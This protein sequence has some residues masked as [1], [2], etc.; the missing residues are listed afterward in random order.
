MGNAVWTGVPLRDVLNAAGVKENAVYTGHYGMDPHLSGDPQKDPLS[1]G[2]PIWKA[3]D[4]HT[5]VAFEMN[6]QPIPALHGFPVRIVAPGWAGSTS[7]KWL[8]RIWV[9]DQVHDGAKMTGKSYRVP[10]YPVEPGPTCPMRI[11]SS[12][13]RC[14]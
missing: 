11:S 10:A 1:R 5:L 8:E 13:S 2:L 9:R 6:G 12:S 3:M 14:R 7:Q 4:P